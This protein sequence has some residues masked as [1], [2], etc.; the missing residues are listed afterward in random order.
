MKKFHRV[1][2]CATWVA[3]AVVLLTPSARNLAAQLR[4][5]ISLIGPLQ[6]QN[7]P[8]PSPTTPPQPATKTALPI[9]SFFR[10]SRASAVSAERRASSPAVAYNPDDNE[11]LVVWESDGLT[12]VKGVSD[13]YGQRINGAT[14]A[15]IG[16]N[17]R[18]S[19]LSDGDNHHSSNDPKVVYNRTTREYLVVWHG[20]GLVDSPDRFFEV[21]GQR[22]SRTGSEIGNDFRISQLT[23]LGKVNSTL[24]RGNTQADVAWNSV[25]NE[26]L[27]IWKGMGEPEEFVKMEIYGQRVK[28]NGD[29]AG[30]HFRISHTTN[31]GTNFQANAP[32]VAYNSRDNQYFVVWTG[33]FK[34][35]VQTE[36]WAKVIPAGG[37]ELSAEDIRISE[38][39]SSDRRANLAHVEYNAGNNEYLVVFQANPIPGATAVVNDIVGQ[40]IGATNPVQVQP[41]YLRISN[42]TGA[43]SR[44]TAPRVAYNNLSKEYL[45][46]W[47]SSRANA[48]VEI[49]GQRLNSAGIEIEGD[50]QI[51]NLSSVGKD[52][53]IHDAAMTHNSS[54]GRYFIVWQ[55]NALVEAASSQI[56]EIFGQPFK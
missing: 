24:V 36:V 14:H 11:Y 42:N 39:S 5:S 31:Q 41:N 54:N 21:Y 47:R 6:T 43:G 44:V 56:Y 45:V 53:G 3:L 50:F 48:P 13:I 30:K 46:I 4:G 55:G 15:P 28:A 27:V 34:R 52:R 23:E 29:L 33:G 8:N 7:K 17:F 16:I 19:N 22:L 51:A 1:L 9:S 10:I 35:E 49:S 38:I 18:I 37:G 32:A 40:R 12:D 2:I 25:N 26:Y 20:L